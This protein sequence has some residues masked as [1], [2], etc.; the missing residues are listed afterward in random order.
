MFLR[1]SFIL[2]KIYWKFEEKDVKR[3]SYQKTKYVERS[4]SNH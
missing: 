3:D 1:V 2:E 4:H